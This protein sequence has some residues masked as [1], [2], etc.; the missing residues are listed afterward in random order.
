MKLKSKMGMCTGAVAVRY[1][2]PCKVLWDIL[3]LTWDVV[4]VV[5]RQFVHTGSQTDGAIGVP[6]V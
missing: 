3:I 1:S 5:P 6:P 2:L 4:E